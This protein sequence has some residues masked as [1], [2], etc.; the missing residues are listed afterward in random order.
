MPHSPKAERASAPC[1]VVGQSTTSTLSLS[2]LAFLNLPTRSR[3]VLTLSGLLFQ[4][5]PMTGFRSAIIGKGKRPMPALPVVADPPCGRPRAE[6]REARLWFG[7]KALFSAPLSTFCKAFSAACARFPLESQ[8]KNASP[9][10]SLRKVSMIDLTGNG[11]A[12]FAR[13]FYNQHKQLSVL[14]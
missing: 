12:S 14:S 3:T 7:M 9:T 5:P 10:A 6:T 4:L 11:Q 8:A 2:N 1:T 13:D